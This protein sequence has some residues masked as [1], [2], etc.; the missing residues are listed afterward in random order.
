L[1]GELF[2]GKIGG[3][4]VYDNPVNDWVKLGPRDIPGVGMLSLLQ[5]PGQRGR[6]AGTAQG[7]FLQT[8]PSL[9]WFALPGPIGRLTVYDLT[10][11]RSGEWVFAGTSDGV[12]RTR[13]DELRFE[14]PPVYR[15]IPRVFSL[16]AAKGDPGTIFAGSH[17]GVLSSKDSGTTWQVSSYGIPDHTIVECLVSDPGREAHLF[18]GTSAGLFESHDSGGTWASVADGRLGVNVPSVIFLDSGG[19]RILAADNTSGGVLL[20]EDAGAHWEKIEDPEFGSP[21]RSMAQDPT[22]PSVIYLGTGTEG[23]YRLT[24]AGP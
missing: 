18:A 19:R 22:H 23:V 24:L 5:L 21:I 6:I 12:Y 10:A 16:L 4:Y 2:E 1:V 14:K 11:D 7:A 9:G 3:L 20:S 13:L 17:F 15:F 8:D